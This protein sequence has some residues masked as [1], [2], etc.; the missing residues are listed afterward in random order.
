MNLKT[1]KFNFGSLQIFDRL[2][3][4]PYMGRQWE[5]TPVKKLPH[6]NYHGEDTFRSNRRR[7]ESSMALEEEEE[8]F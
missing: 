3:S 7:W 6:E 1:F 2:L 8:D 5:T 4:D